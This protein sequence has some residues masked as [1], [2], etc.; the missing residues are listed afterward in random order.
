MPTQ[1][2]RITAIQGD[3]LTHD[4]PPESF[5]WIVSVSAIE[6]TGPGHYG[7]PVDHDGDSKAMRRAW[8]WLKPGG[9]M[10]F[11]VPWNAGEDAYQV[12]G[13]S[14]RVYDSDA[15]RSRV[16][17]DPPV[18]WPERMCIAHKKRVTELVLKPPRLGGGED[19]YY[20]GIWLRKP[21]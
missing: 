14:H 15:L 8:G 12:V 13:T 19:F 20:C 9:L 18:G 17:P 5:D 6:H 7:D 11:D 10:F 3:V 4:F 16:V 2:E 21:A 1:P